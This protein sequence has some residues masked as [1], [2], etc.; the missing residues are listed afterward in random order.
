M[1]FHQ[2]KSMQN[3]QSLAVPCNKFTPVSTDIWSLLLIWSVVIEKRAWSAQDKQT[4]KT[5]ETKRCFEIEH[6]HILAFNIKY[7]CYY[8]I[9]DRS[10]VHQNERRKG[11]YLNCWSNVWMQVNWYKVQVIRT[12]SVPHHLRS[13]LKVWFPFCF[14][15]SEILSTLLKFCS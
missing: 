1:L 13:W 10:I 3:L 4:N 9:S 5:A 2:Y 12:A 6:V 8:R 11:K 15:V 7:L 14:S